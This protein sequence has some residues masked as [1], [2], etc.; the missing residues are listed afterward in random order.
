MMNS[1]WFNKFFCLLLFLA[2]PVISVGQETKKHVCKARVFAALRPMPKLDYKCQPEEVPDYGDEVLKRPERVAALRKYV[3]S[4]AD[5]TSSDWWNA[6]VNDLNACYVG[7]KPGPLSPED[8]EALRYGGKGTELFGDNSVR[9]ILATDPC[10]QR[11]FGGS[12]AF[13][14]Y[15]SD[16]RVYVTEAI[17]G[18]YSRSDNPMGLDFGLLKSERII[19]I[20]TNSGGLHPTITNYYFIIDRKSGKAVPKKLFR[21][22]GKLTNEIT[23]A[24]DL[25]GQYQDPTTGESTEMQVIKHGKLAKSF[26]V[27]KE[28]FS[29]ES[30]T[31]GPKLNK[32][33]YRWNGSF[34]AVGH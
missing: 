10:Y 23:S 12:N 20:N 18:F 27:L 8:E 29:R 19:E 22:G 28:D 16:D 25:Y 5:L 24:M 4:L 31:D 32:S 11:E 26:I 33:T 34:Y 3:R 30:G 13:L 7:G 21:V 6:D 1:T 15:R 2:I 17:D 14:L 9:L